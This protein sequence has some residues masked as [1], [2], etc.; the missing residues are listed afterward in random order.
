MRFWR[1]IVLTLA[2]AVVAI[3]A[4]NIVVPNAVSA[5][6]FLGALIAVYFVV[7]DYFREYGERRSLNQRVRAKCKTLSDSERAMLRLMLDEDG[8]TE[9]RM[10]AAL[11]SQGLPESSTNT[12][13]ENTGFLTCDF[14]GRWEIKESRREAIKSALNETA[15]RGLQI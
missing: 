13:Y 4:R 11:I 14:R 2:L 6:A 9:A 12:L 5:F 15:F 3:T 7:Q 8:A 1:S 10:H